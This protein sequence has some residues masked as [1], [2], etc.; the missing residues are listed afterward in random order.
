MTFFA[1]S[2]WPT[3]SLRS[4]VILK[5]VFPISLFSHSLT[6]VCVKIAWERSFCLQESNWVQRFNLT[7]TTQ[8]TVLYE[9]KMER[10]IF[11]F[12][13]ERLDVRK[14]KGSLDIQRNMVWNL[15]L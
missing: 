7:R 15:P 5:W 6:N 11:T 12:F 2:S 10:L 1:F 13:S 4:L 9:K 3:S 14:K 8:T